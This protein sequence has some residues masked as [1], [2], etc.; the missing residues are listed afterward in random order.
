MLEATSNSNGFTVHRHYRRERRYAD[1]YDNYGYDEYE[2]ED[3]KRCPGPVRCT[4]II[5]DIGALK[6]DQEVHVA[7]RSRLWVATI[8]KVKLS[9]ILAH[10]QGK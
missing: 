10:Y 1:E 2:E 9:I 8:K 7:V 6:K 3:A 4:R 5:C